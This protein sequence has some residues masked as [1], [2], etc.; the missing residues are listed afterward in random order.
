MPSTTPNYK[1]TTS[2]EERKQK[3][4]KMTVSYPDR[5]P[6]IIE[7][8]S[9]SASYQSYIA[10]THKVKYLVPYDL[11]MGQFIK[12]LRDKIIKFSPLQHPSVLYIKKK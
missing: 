2:L 8:S 6:V 5:I 11:T 10:A 1:K 7:M 4:Y 12:I 9:S 3:S